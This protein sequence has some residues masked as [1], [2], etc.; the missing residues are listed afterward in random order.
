M[1]NFSNEQ[2]NLDVLIL[3]AGL[4]TRMRSNLAKV[5]HKLDARPL[6]NHVCLTATA[7]APRKIYVV[8]GHQGEDVTRAVLEELS[9]EH[10]AFVWQK[11]QLGTGHAVNSAR[12]FLET[13]D[14]TLLILS[15]DVPMIRAETLAALVQQHHNHRGKG[16]ACTILT[17]KLDEPKG[18]GRIVRDEAGFFSRIV[19]QKDASEEEKL[20]KEINSGI[21]CF[22]TKKLFSALS[23]VQNNNVQGEYYLTDVPALLREAGEDISL[24]QHTDARE[25]SGINNRAELADLERIISRRT[26]TRMMIDYGV[27][28][29]D[30]KNT[31]I[32][33]SANIGRDTVIYPNVTIEGETSIGDGCTIRQ[34]TRITNSRIGR[35]VEILDNCVITDS[36][37][38]DNCR[39]GPFAHLRGKA[40]MEESAKVGN[41]VELKKTILGRSSKASHLTYLGDATIGEKTN[42][43]AGTITCN[44]DGV[45]KHATLIEDNVKIGSDTM[46]VAPVRV[47]SGSVTGAGSVV[48]K[49]V[50][51][52]S[53]V[54]GVPARVKKSLKEESQIVASEN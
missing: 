11:E 43:G 23:S 44:Y 37:I 27:S 14:S 19:E 45:N 16:A 4:G 9:E 34:G 42:I 26:I 52:D 30:P 7:L 22:N 50:P 35:N 10:A 15:G 28:F 32:N 53:L 29:I 38:S 33:E 49:D 36:E 41:F 6:I 13:E 5:L 40:K 48:T 21:Y 17:V 46:L 54:A 39:V 12:E 8:I 31:Y 20:I 47:G 2:K 25:V 24:Y 18:Y 3:A 1:D 51:P